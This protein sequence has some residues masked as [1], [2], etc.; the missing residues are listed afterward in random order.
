MWKWETA[1]APYLDGMRTETIRERFAGSP[2][3]R[4]LNVLRLVRSLVN[5]GLDRATGRAIAVSKPVAR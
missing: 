2:R 1:V 5:R 3:D 4:V